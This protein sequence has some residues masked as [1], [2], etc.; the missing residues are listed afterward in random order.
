MFCLKNPTVYDVR[1]LIFGLSPSTADYNFEKGL[2]L[3]EKTL[4]AQMP[5]RKFGSL[6][7][8]LDWVQQHPVLTM[9]VTE[10]R[11][12]RPKDQ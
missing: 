12:Q 7:A 6:T 11:I 3:L 10:V 4:Q 1:G 8:F 2:T 9:D 5:A